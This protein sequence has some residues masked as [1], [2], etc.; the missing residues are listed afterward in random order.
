MLGRIE[1]VAGGVELLDTVALEH[2]DQLR[3]HETH[4]LCQVLLTLLCRGQCPLEVVDDGQQLADEP[5]LRPATRSG[6]LTRGTLPVVLE[7]GLDA[8]SEREVILARGLGLLGLLLLAEPTLLVSG[9]L[10]S[11][12]LAGLVA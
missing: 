4:S 10:L 8:L 11:G 2:G 1:L 6:R 5:A 12:G 7:I 9:I 3:V